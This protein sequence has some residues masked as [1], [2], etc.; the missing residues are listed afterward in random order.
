M[1]SKERVKRAIEFG[2]PD[3]VPYI[4]SNH[5]PG[6]L[7]TDI[8][9]IA[10]I[11][12]SN[13]QPPDSPPNYPHVHPLLIQFGLYKWDTSKWPNGKPP[14]NWQRLPRIEIDEWNGIWD[15]V[16]GKTMGHPS[17]PLIKT[18]DDLDKIRIP[19][20]LNTDRLKLTH[21]L[22]RLFPSK[23]K[24]GFMDHFLFERSHFLRGFNNVLIDFRRNPDKMKELISRIKEY[25][26]DC[27]RSLAQFGVDGVSTP[28][29]LG[30]QLSPIISPKI[31]NEFYRDAYAEIVELSHK[32]KMHFHLHSCGNIGDLMPILVD[33]IGVDVLSFDS[34]HMVGLETAKKYTGRVC[35]SNCVNIQSIYPFGTPNDV[36]REVAR[37]IKAVGAKGGGLMIIDYFGAPSTLNVPMKNVKA[38]W[39]AVRTYGKYKENGESI[40]I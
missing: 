36:Y 3:R 27:V 33:D 17:R 21:T 13:F 25:F 4:S 6:I 18:W 28:D 15:C 32:Y 40:L 11:P 24:L 22:S 31:F 26:L 20:G 10:P 38:M 12:D 19:D 9:P 7:T 5:L 8:F 39:N 37:M 30:T 14:R 29:D 35:F 16:D 2:N 23:Y 34:P 1:K